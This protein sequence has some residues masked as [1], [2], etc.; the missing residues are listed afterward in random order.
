VEPLPREKSTWQRQAW[1]SPHFAILH[2]GTSSGRDKRIK[3]SDSCFPSALTAPGSPSTWL[4]LED[5]MGHLILGTCVSSL[6]NGMWAGGEC[7]GRPSCQS[8]GYSHSTER[9]GHAGI[10]QPWGQQCQQ[11]LFTLR[12]WC[13]STR[14]AVHPNSSHCPLVPPPLCSCP[15]YQ[16]L[17]K[18]RSLWGIPLTCFM[19]LSKSGL[20]V[21]LSP[22]SCG[23]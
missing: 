21:L 6:F 17:R 22:K 12:Q 7:L 1:T 16:E 15:V 2:F 23:S 4:V 5:A 20:C 11:A 10:C 14:S 3:R 18:P 19:H 9:C 8:V 13:A